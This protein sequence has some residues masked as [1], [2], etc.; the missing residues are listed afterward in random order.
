M[1]EHL[2]QETLT[3]YAG[4]ALSPTELLAA[5]DHLAACAV[6]R[7][8]LEDQSEA[9][10]VVQALRAE[11]AATPFTHLD[12]EQLEA[13]VDGAAGEVERE[14]VSNHA[15]LCAACADELNELM[16]LKSQFEARSASRHE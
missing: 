14:I 13:V 12:Y 4:R 6:C 15:Q 11:S 5:D 1:A 7:E 10:A 3:R 8:R 2:S 9:R 16:A